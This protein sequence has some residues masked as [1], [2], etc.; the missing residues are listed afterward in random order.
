[1]IYINCIDLG[2]YNKY[3]VQHEHIQTAAIWKKENKNYTTFKSYDDAN[4]TA[5]NRSEIKA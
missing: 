4:S 2:I 5:K 1:M 3:R